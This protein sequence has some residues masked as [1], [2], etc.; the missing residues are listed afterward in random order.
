M[1]CMDCIVRRMTEL[2]EQMIR[3]VSLILKRIVSIL[4]VGLTIQG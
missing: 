1:A 3:L 4:F 2:K